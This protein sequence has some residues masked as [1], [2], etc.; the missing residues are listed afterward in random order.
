MKPSLAWCSRKVS[1]TWSLV[2]WT[3]GRDD[4]AGRLVAQLDDV[5]AEIGL[6]RRDADRFEML[7]ERDLLGHHRLRLGDGAGVHALAE[8]GDDAP[9]VGGGRRPMDVAAQADDLALELLEIEI[10][11]G[12]RVVLDV[13]RAVA[14]RLELGQPFG[15]LPAPLGEADLQHGRASPAGCGSASAWS[16]FSLKAWAVDS[17]SRAPVRRSPAGRPCRP[18]PRRRGAPRRRCPRAAAC[19][20]CSSG[21]RDRRPAA[22]RRRWPRCRPIFSPTMA[23]EISG[24]FT[25]KV[26]P[27]PQQTSGVFISL[28]VRPSTEREQPARLLLDAE[29]AQARAGIVI[30]DGAVVARGDLARRP[31]RRPGT[32]SARSCGR[33]DSPR[34]AFIAGSSSN[35]PG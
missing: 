4:V 20:P 26:P 9:R 21:S 14:Q 34:A 31:A 30:G 7:V 13:A 18:A 6:D 12:Q 16:T 1:A 23:F 8:L 29:L 11:M 19:P 28:S 3:A 24:Y 32:T 2:R 25:Q 27:K 10:E 33:R 17:I 35:R 22:C 5:L 15:R